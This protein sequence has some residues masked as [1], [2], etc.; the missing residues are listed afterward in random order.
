MTGGNAALAL[1]M[2][3]PAGIGPDLSLVAWRDREKLHLPP[4]SCL[5][6]QTC[7]VRV[8][9]CWGS[10]FHLSKPH[11]NAQLRILHTPCPYF[12]ST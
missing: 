11:R 12:R 7:L 10:T 8:P 2:G 9:R 3:D 4:F 6:I 1:T 5:E